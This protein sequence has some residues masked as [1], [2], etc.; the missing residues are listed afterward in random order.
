LEAALQEEVRLATQVNQQVQ[1]ILADRRGAIRY[2]VNGR[3]EHP[4][5]WD[6]INDCTKTGQTPDYLLS[7]QEPKDPFAQ[8]Q[9]TES[10]F[11]R[12]NNAAFGQPAAQTSPAF[13]QP[14]APTT[15]AFE[16]QQQQ[17]QA[18]PTN[19]SLFG[20]P[21]FIQNTTSFSQPAFSQPPQS[22]FGTTS[23]SQPT[24]PAF[25]QPPAAS[26]SAFSQ[27]QQSLP[28]GAK[29]QVPPFTAPLQ[30][31][32]QQQPP[33]PELTKIPPNSQLAAFLSTTGTN[34]IPTQFPDAQPPDS[35]YGSQTAA[36]QNAFATARE[37]GEFPDGVVPEVAPKG[38]WVILDWQ[39]N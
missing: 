30:Q 11:G 6:V 19:Q 24:Q 32:P 3:N 5:R 38:E 23:F 27:Q 14:S 34:T 35:A 31:Q 29:Q 15:S 21:A 20:Q 12:G 2:V 28:L 25:S 22:V 13:G 10:T 4:N 37:K 9:S 33:I 18:P 1:A 39:G 16:Q 26:T 7:N 8:Q 17:Q 36:L